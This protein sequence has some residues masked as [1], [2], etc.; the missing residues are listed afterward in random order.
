MAYDTELTKS[1][2][3]GGYPTAGVAVTFAA[4]D[5]AGKNYFISTGR[6]LLVARNTSADTPYTITIVSAADEMGRTG[7]ITAESIAFGVTRMYGPF[8]RSG[9]SQSTGHINV[10]AANEA[11][12]FAVIQLP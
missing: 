2:A 12:E 3:P 4:A 10:E 5:V 7:N 11:I 9:W 6:E 1:T 8:P